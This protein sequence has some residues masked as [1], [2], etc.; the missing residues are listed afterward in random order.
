MKTE[1]TEVTWQKKKK[2][3]KKICNSN[4]VIQ[5]KTKMKL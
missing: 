3:Y 1:F 5:Y 4:R 2:D